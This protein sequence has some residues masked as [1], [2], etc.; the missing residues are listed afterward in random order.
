LKAIANHNPTLGV[1][2][3]QQSKT[4]SFTFIAPSPFVSNT[5]MGYHLIKMADVHIE[6]YSL[7]GQMIQVIDKGRQ[8]EGDYQLQW[9]ADKLSNGIYFVSLKLNGVSVDRKKVVKTN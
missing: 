7:N 4:G 6:V 9:N 3:L 8:E 5:Q 1:Q 2:E